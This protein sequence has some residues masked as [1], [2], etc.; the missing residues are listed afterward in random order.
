MAA[1]KE[2][3]VVFRQRLASASSVWMFGHGADQPVPL[4]KWLGFSLS[5]F[6]GGAELFRDS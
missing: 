1:N 4:R 2:V 5:D 6:G 3:K